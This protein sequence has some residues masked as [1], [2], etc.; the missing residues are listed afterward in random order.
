MFDILM[1]LIKNQLIFLKQTFFK[2]VEF[3]DFYS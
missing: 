3:F 2:Y 1:Y